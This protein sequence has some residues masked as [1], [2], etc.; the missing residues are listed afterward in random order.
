MKNSTQT[1][2]LGSA[3]PPFNLSAANLEGSFSL[4]D[5]I[6]TGPLIIEFLRGTW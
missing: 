2:R 3:A 5:L 6:A 4:R 1:L